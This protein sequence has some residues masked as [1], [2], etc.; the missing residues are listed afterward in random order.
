[1]P[2]SAPHKP[3]TALIVEDQAIVLIE[4]AAQ[5][6]DM[7][8]AVLTASNADEAIAMLDAHAEIS[9]LLTDIRMPGSMDG[10]R[11]AHHVR[12]RWPPVRIIVISGL[13]DLDVSRLPADS[14]F[15]PKPYRPEVLTGA[16]MHMID[17]A[18]PRTAGG[19][20]ARAHG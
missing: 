10:L 2:R 8:L 19:G 5:L 4:L 18:G 14:I 17:G 6:E 20:S 1:M 13:I 11:L 3:T 7:G 12:H 15:L 16:L 9:L